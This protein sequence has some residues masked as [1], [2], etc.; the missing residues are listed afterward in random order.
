M[1]PVDWGAALAELEQRRAE[2]DH[3]IVTVRRLAGAQLATPAPAGNGS[4]KRRSAPR[5]V[6][7]KVSPEQ[8]AQARVRWD[9]GEPTDAIAAALKITTTSVYDHAK[10]HKW[11]KRP[12]GGSRAKPVREPKGEQLRAR[13]RCPGCESM[14]EWDP[15]E[16]CGKAIAFKG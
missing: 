15:C 14:T 12:R 11:P 4:S 9:R 5:A 10:A 3:A 8:W 13:V 16:H 6:Y 2:L 7:G 1:S